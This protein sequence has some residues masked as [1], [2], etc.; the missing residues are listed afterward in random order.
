MEIWNE[1]HRRGYAFE[2]KKVRN[3]G[4]KIP[5]MT[6]TRGQIAYEWEHLRKKLRKRDPARL[7]TFSKVLRPKL[8]PSFRAKPGPIASWEKI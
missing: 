1:A 7:K 2:K 5:D 3:A 4:T 6:V 8:H